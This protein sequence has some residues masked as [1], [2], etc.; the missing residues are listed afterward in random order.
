MKRKMEHIFNIIAGP[1]ADTCCI[2]L[3]GEIGSYGDVTAQNIVTRLMEAEQTYHKIDVRINSVGGEVETGIAIFNALR[4]SKADITIYIDCIAASTASFIAAC[5]RTV[6]MSRYARMMLHRPSGGAW[7]DASH[8]KNYIAQL[9]QIEE[10]LCRIYAER[11][12]RTVE[13][14]RTTY[15]DGEDH[16]LTAD[17]A[18]SLGFVDEIYDDVRE[19]S[20]TDSLTPHERCERYTACYLESIQQV[21]HKTEKQ[22]INKLKERPTFTDCADEAAIIN[23]IAEFEAKATKYDAIVAERDALKE[24]VA[25]FEQK[26]REAAEAAYDAEVDRARA[27]ERISAAEVESFKAL[28]RK[29]PEATRT[30][31][32]ARKPKR[33]VMDVLGGQSDPVEAKTD[34][35]FLAAREAEVWAKLKKQ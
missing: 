15:M 25:G 11:T 28:M 24:K 2:L 29:D 8:L 6:K 30:L 10:V 13:D 33:R 3:Y 18:L 7:G 5:G 21:S 16:W 34:K 14:I 19:V 32:N 17:E 31:L 4:Q 20:F 9:E 23:R 1:Q 12:G 22:M 26:E 35:D 27:E